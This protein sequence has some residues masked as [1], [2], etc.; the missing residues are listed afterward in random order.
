MA[1][2]PAAHKRRH[3]LRKNGLAPVGR[4]ESNI[5]DY[6]ITYCSA[7][8]GGIRPDLLVLVVLQQWLQPHATCLH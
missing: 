4:T 6:G 8:L 2:V 7:G 5:T 1:G 3:A